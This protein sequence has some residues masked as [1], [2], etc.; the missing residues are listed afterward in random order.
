MEKVVIVTVEGGVVQHV[1]CPA[2]VKVVV[3][4]YDAEGVEA[5]LLS[6]DDHGGEYVE[7]VWE[8]DP[9]G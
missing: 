1:E 6:A 9:A 7:S 8:G 3:K 5:D 2:G 4:D